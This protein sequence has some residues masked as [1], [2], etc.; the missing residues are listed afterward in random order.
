MSCPGSFFL[1]SCLIPH[2]S[3]FPSLLSSSITL[4]CSHPSPS[5]VLIAVLQYHPSSSRFPVSPALI[6]HPPLSSSITFSCPHCCSPVSSFILLPH[7]RLSAALS[8]LIFLVLGL[9]S[10]LSFPLSG[11]V[12]VSCPYHLSHPHPFSLSFVAP[13]SFILPCFRPRHPLLSGDGVV[14]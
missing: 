9:S 7:S 12:L 10:L 13:S 11:H 3:G 5:S 4:S 2:P 8:P 1:L 6:H 14:Q